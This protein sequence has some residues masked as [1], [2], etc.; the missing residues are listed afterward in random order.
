MPAINY[1]LVR[2]L[3][4]FVNSLWEVPASNLRRELRGFG[5]LLRLWCSPWREAGNH[6]RGGLWGLL[7]V[8]AIFVTAVPAQAEE[9][10][11]T[12]DIAGIEGELEDQVRG[13]L[14]KPVSTEPAMLLS[15][16]HI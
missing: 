5:V 7:L 16:I 12:I 15:L 13:R 14:G 10:E 4:D 8:S 2:S 3:G 1:K 11:V 9:L 6:S